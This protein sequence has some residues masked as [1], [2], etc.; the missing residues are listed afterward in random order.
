MNLPAPPLRLAPKDRTRFDA[1]AP[2]PTL[3][4]PHTSWMVK[5]CDDWAKRDGLPK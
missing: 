1:L 3:L 5:T 4:E 2:G